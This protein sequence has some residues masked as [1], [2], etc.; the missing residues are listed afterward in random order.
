MA[1]HTRPSAIPFAVSL[2]AIFAF[3]LSLSCAPGGDAPVRFAV[4]F[5]EELSAEPLDGRLVL[6]LSTA[7][8]GEPRFQIS[9]GPNTQLAFGV[10]VEGWAPG[11]EARSASPAAPR[12]GPRRAFPTTWRR[13]AGA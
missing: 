8:E 6:M 1:T 4:T 5:P 9:D 7:V 12:R 2:I 10:D 11:A 13:C 3:A